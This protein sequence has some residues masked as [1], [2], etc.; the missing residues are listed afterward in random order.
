M[1][2]FL[3]IEFSWVWD[4]ASKSNDILIQNDCR[5]VYFHP[6]YSCGTAAVR[7]KRLLK[8]GEEHYWDIRMC[9]AVYGTDMVWSFNKL[10]LKVNKMALTS[11]F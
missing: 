5:E 10:M 9:S 2:L 8:E 1:L 6:D 11:V 7:G 4:P 3:F